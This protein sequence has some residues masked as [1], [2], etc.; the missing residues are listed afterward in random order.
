MLNQIQ[1][2]TRTY[3]S[4]QDQ[5]EVLQYL[6]NNPD[7]PQETLS[8][9]AK[10][11]SSLTDSEQLTELNNQKKQQLPSHTVML[12]EMASKRF[13]KVNQNKK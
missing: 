10:E 12:L 1:Y 11:N 13:S 4:I 6:I 2:L 9:P 7:I 5:K 8:I 3:L